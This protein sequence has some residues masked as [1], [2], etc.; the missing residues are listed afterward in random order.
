M[1]R[2]GAIFLF[3]ALAAAVF[4]G[5]FKY[6][7]I[8]EAKR[9]EAEKQIETI[10]VYTDLPQGIVHLLAPAFEQ[11]YGVSLSVRDMSGEEM[12]EGAGNGQTP[13]VYIAS[14]RALRQLRDAEALLPYVSEETDVVLNRCKDDEGFWTGIWMDPVVFAVSEE[15]AAAHSGFSYLWDE[16]LTRQDIRLGM[17]DFIVSEYTEESLISLVE[18][19]GRE[20]TFQRLRN[21]ASHIVQYGKYMSTP[22]QM[23]A[24]DKCDIGISSLHEA[25]KVQ[26]EGLP[27]RIVYPED[28]TFY[29]LYGAAIS[30]TS[31]Q[32]ELAGCLVD[33]LLNHEARASILGQNGYY[34]T[35]VNHVRMMKD[36]LQRKL[37][38]WPIEKRYT[39]EGKEALLNQWLQEIR[40]GK[41]ST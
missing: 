7:E 9:K 24:M 36:A 21:A 4:L 5:L 41:E 13:D 28:G 6:G 40:F 37:Y 34:F 25:E 8:R 14:Q 3:L 30:K 32:S 38:F 27:V 20:E 35:H 26:Q 2:S 12:L 22:A 16:V 10:E 19:F 17:T 11:T 18:H 33:W 39:E 29:Y 23:A 31:R 15:F 1:R